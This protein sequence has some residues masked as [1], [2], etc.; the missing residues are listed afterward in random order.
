MK[1]ARILLTAVINL[2]QNNAAPK[3]F[4]NLFVNNAHRTIVDNDAQ[5]W[6]IEGWPWLLMF[7]TS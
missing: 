4:V 1:Q 7:W 5:S 3:Q 2:I 6:C